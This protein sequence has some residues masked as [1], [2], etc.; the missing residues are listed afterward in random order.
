M[1]SNGS[2]WNIVDSAGM[3]FSTDTWYH[4]ALVRYGTS[5]KL[6]VNGV[7]NI[8]TSSS[9]GLVDNSVSLSIG[10]MLTGEYSMNGYIDELRISK[11]VARWTSNFTPPTQPYSN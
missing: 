3:L 11:G 8:S 5:I 7:S 1:S 9:L 10:S 4:I 6:Y 2:T